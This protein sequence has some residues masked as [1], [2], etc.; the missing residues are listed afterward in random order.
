MSF[1]LEIITFLECLV[2]YLI[3]GYFYCI[4][5]FPTVFETFVGVVLDLCFDEHLLRLFFPLRHGVW[6]GFHS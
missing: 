1:T 5:S 2:F 6:R 4:V 3:W